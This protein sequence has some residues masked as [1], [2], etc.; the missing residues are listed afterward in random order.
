MIERFLA[1]KDA[2]LPTMAILPESPR[3]P[4]ALKLQMLQELV[5]ILGPFYEIT[6][7]TSA[8]KMFQFQKF[9]QY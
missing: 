7:E 2:V 6:K 9:F 1:V 3:L 5:V 4:T 8:E